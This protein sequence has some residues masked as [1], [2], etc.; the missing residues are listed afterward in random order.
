M[1]TVTSLIDELDTGESLSRILIVESAAG[2]S[3]RRWLEE[4]MKL[5][6]VS[7]ARTF[8][9]SCDFS[10]RGPWAGVNELFSELFVEIQS[11]RTDLVERHALELVYI[12]PQLRRSLAVH[13]PCLTDLASPEEKTR[14]YPA[15]R[16][17]RIV[18][19][20][21]DLLD[22]WKSATC[23]DTKWVI[24]CDAYDLAGTM[25]GCFFSELMRRKGERLNLRLIIGVA[26]GKGEQTRNSLSTGVR[27]DIVAVNLP[28]EP[29][30]VLYDKEAAQMAGDLER[31]IG[32][33]R[34]EMQ[35]HLSDLI[36]LW[37][38]AGRP[39]KVLRCK[40]FA[41]ETYNTLGLYEDALRYSEGILSLAREHAPD[42]EPLQWFIIF[43]LLMCHIGL[44]H[45]QSSLELALEEGMKLAERNA[46]RR[47][48][49]FYHIA[50]LYARYQQPRDLVKGEE[51]LNR[52]LEAIEEANLPGGV[53]H[54]QYAFNRNGLAMI[55][56]FQGR[57]EEAIELC[58]S[59]IARLNA[60]LSAEEHRLHRSIL[61]YNIAQVYSVTG[62]FANAIEYYS[63]AITMDPNYSE[64]YNERGNAFL[65]LGHLQEAFNDY[66]RAI[67]L[68]PPYFEV[69]VN[70]GQCYRR[71]G[72]MAEAIE[73]YSRA[74]DLQPDHLLA[75]L[76][77]A[78]A[79]EELG[80]REAAIADYTAALVQDP[81]QWE[82]IASRGVI[83]YEAGNLDMS[84]ADFDQAIELKPD[85]PDLYYNRA[86]VLADLGR[87]HQAEKDVEAALN[88]NPAKEDKLTLEALLETVRQAEVA[89]KCGDLS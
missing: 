25:G 78:K 40:F 34:I 1:T 87:Y 4:H 45:V 19:G 80:H 18:H 14:N 73:S 55:R 27:A 49:L 82:A 20:L 74:H 67:D 75:L 6:E 79:H 2:P 12:L 56:N 51:Y 52:A 62:S 50:M 72:A 47:G 36:R 38:S 71:M 22:S 86:T 66:L 17:L 37:Q 24:A 29:P 28:M 53:F 83:H 58:R 57:F 13:N 77:R 15:D 63:A 3:R 69:F 7:G 89:E 68:S 16:A 21:I 42:D 64:Y 30:A 33:D 10:A 60:H 61:L 76:G 70:L 11:Q 54:F 35:L 43:K 59:G 88:L 26:P 32:D 48:R 41:L 81:K 23:A 44:K 85:Q 8:S 39:D 84:L 9:V 46:D 65:Q 31:R 5:S